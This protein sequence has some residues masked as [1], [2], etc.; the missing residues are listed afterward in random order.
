LN[1]FRYGSAIHF[2]EEYIHIDD[3]LINGN[4]KKWKFRIGLPNKFRIT[5][6]IPGIYLEA[7]SCAPYRFSCGI[8]NSDTLLEYFNIYS[9]KLYSD[10]GKIILD[11]LM[12]NKIYFERIPYWDA[13][14]E[15]TKFNS[16][17]YFQIKQDLNIDIVEDVYINSIVK[18]SVPPS[19]K[20]F[21][22]KHRFKLKKYVEKKRLFFEYNHI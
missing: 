21:L 9:V 1:G 14:S 2:V 17:A 6:H 13:E 18:I 19:D 8:L 5:K 4:I 10:D 12:E 15:T 22:I 7:S 16:Q 3:T 20:S 11:S